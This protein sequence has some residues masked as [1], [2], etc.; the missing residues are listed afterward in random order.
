[1][2]KIQWLISKDLQ[3]YP[4]PREQMK[5]RHRKSQLLFPANWQLCYLWVCEQGEKNKKLHNDDAYVSIY[6]CITSCLLGKVQPKLKPSQIINLQHP[7]EVMNEALWREMCPK[8]KMKLIA[9]DWQ[10]VIFYLWMVLLGQLFPDT[11]AFIVN[12]VNYSMTSTWA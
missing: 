6:S 12:L 4:K 7:L 9:D 10:T 5:F 3:M 8:K 1:M 2:I 11:F